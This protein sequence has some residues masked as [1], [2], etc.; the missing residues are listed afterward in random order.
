[1]G[2]ERGTEQSPEGKGEVE[3]KEKREK[4]TQTS[5]KRRGGAGCWADKTEFIVF[6]FCPGSVRFIFCQQCT[7]KKKMIPKLI[8][9][10]MATQLTGNNAVILKSYTHIDSQDE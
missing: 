4:K 2:P 8:S 10:H 1:M 5:G 3:E 9:L 7:D 6:Q